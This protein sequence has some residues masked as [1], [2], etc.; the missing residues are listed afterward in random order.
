M[1]FETMLDLLWGLGAIIDILKG[2][3]DDD[4]SL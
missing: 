3:D 2:R 4:F 1:R